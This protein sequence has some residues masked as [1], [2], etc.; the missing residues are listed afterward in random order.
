MTS[1]SKKPITIAV[2]GHSSCGKSTLAKALARELNFTYID[3]GAMY[4][5]VT[6]YCKRKGWV[7]AE[8]VDLEKIK[9][10]LPEISL[11]F[12]IE[13]NE[14]KNTL[15]LNQENVEDEIREMA[16]SKFVSKIASIAEVR[17]KLVAEQRKMGQSGGV[18]MDGRDIG[19]VVFPDAELKLFVTA[20]IEVR[21]QRRFDELQAKGSDVTLQEVQENLAERDHLDSTRSESP[22]IQTEDAVVLDNS[23]LDK[24]EQLLWVL[25]V[26]SE[27]S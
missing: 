22:L 25:K 18:V 16:V 21:A 26:I 14:S 24:K 8:R 2:D 1:T 20:S 27:I 4:R 17:T 12:N 6:L 11:A 3:S 19:S 7:S 9:N 10:G 13:G 5:G 15:Y 23:H